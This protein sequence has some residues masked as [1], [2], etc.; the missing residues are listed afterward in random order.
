METEKNYVT[1]ARAKWEEVKAA[2]D[3]ELDKQSKRTN[4]ASE[5][6]LRGHLRSVR[7]LVYVP[8]RDASLA[9]AKSEETARAQ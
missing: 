1:A 2:I 7:E 4:R 8:Y 6:R 9:D 5:S 3:A